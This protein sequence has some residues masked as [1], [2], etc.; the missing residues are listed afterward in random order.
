M[1]TDKLI[2]LA[3]SILVC[4]LAGFVGQFFTFPS[5]ATWYARL[6]KPPLNPPNWIFG[7]VWTLLYILMAVALYLVISDKK[8]WSDISEGVYSFALQ[9]VL[10]SYWSIIFFGYHLPLL[11][12][13]ELAALWCAILATIILFYQTSKTATW[14]MVPYILWVSFAGYLN[15]AIWWLNR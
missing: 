1:R 5:I 9:L 2:K 14:L 7:P 4:L 3:G 11:A 13:V 15:I 12:A 6:N 8:K 10:N